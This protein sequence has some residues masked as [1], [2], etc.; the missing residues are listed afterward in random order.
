MGNTYPE[1]NDPDR[2]ASLTTHELL[3]ETESLVALLETICFKPEADGGALVREVKKLAEREQ[4]RAESRILVRAREMSQRV[5]SAR[6]ADWV[7]FLCMFRRLDRCMVEEFGNNSEDRPNFAS[8]VRER[9][10]D[11]IREVEKKADEVVA[12]MEEEEREGSRRVR[13][14]RVGESTRIV[15]NAFFGPAEPFRFGSRRWLDR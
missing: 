8:K 9:F 7:E 10:W 13:R 4:Y 12:Q 14:E 15:S 11:D 6:F 5:G 2:A 3:R 1:D